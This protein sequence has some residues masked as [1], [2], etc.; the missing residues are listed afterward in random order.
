MNLPN[1]SQLQDREEI[2]NTFVL[3]ITPN[4]R[5]LDGSQ[6]SSIQSLPL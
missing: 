1:Q 3:N 4:T 5:T 6:E 2:G